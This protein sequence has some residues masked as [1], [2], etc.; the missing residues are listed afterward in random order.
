VQ[1]EEPVS[2]VTAGQKSVSG[3][4]TALVRTRETATGQADG[5][6]IRDEAGHMHQL[7]YPQLLQAQ[8]MIQR[9]LESQRPS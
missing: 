7:S 8:A 5:I 1:Y 2:R 3:E 9:Y 4:P 6:Y